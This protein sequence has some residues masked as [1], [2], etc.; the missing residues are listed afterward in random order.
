MQNIDVVIIGAGQAGLAASFYLKQSGIDHIVFEKG[1]IGETWRSQRWDNFAINT[2]N[3][4]NNLAGL[5]VDFARPDAFPNRDELVDYLESYVKQFDLP[6]RENCP[7]EK[8]DQD[9]SGKFLVGLSN[10]TIQ[11]H[12]VI[13]AAGG[14][15]LPKIPADA[16]KLSSKITSLHAGS[17]RSASQLP[18]GAVLV[19]GSGQSGCQIAEDLIRADRKVYLCT[20]R[21]GRVP[22]VYRGR[23]FMAWWD[24]MGLWGKRVDELEDLAL[25][26]IP[27]PQVSGNDGGHTLSLQ[28]LAKHGAILLGRLGKIDGKKLNIH[29]NLL[30]NI[31]YAD[32]RS[33]FYKAQIDGLIEQQNIDAPPPEPDPG[34]PPMPNLNG[35]E[36][37]LE[38]DLDACEI[39]SLIWCT[40][41]DADWIL[42]PEEY[43]DSDGQPRHQYGISECP[44]LY[45]IGMPWIHRR[46]SGIL[47]GVSDDAKHI[48]M[49]IE[50]Q[51]Q[52]R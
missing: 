42:V 17:Y 13:L 36:N 23:D 45:F 3:W 1:R 12:A 4:S 30:E 8:L 22:R 19:V 50:Q 14:L 18:D 46:S 27:H 6:I 33:E 44:G 34:E 51:L 41:F 2:P 10:E 52:S 21:V 47:Y 48:V 7:V 11:A 16:R 15:T 32:E 49:Q 5:E 35:S 38:L 43:K 20:S 37:I 28:L 25:P 40:G 31:K 24:D 9:T 26:F 29:D 39:T